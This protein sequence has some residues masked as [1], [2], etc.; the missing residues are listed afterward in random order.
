MISA[1]QSDGC[2]NTKSIPVLTR[3]LNCVNCMRS[4]PF[5]VGC[6]VCCKGVVLGWCVSHLSSGIFCDVLTWD[7][8]D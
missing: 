4:T 1:L 5:P 2:D 7:M 3:R 8:L 6:F